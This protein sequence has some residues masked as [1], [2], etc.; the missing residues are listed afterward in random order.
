MFLTLIFLVNKRFIEDVFEKRFIKDDATDF[1][2]R[3]Q[4]NVF[5]LYKKN[6]LYIIYISYSYYFY[7]IFSFMTS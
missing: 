7:K 2:K 6:T 4:S 3:F 5:N 1:I